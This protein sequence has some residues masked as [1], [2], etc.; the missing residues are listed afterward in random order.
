MVLVATALVSARAEIKTKTI[1]YMDGTT[2]LKGMMAWDG[3]QNG[4][5]PGILVIGEWWG[6]N[7]AN[8][9]RARRLA[10][11]GYVAFAPDMY[12]DGK[13]T[14]NPKQAGKWMRQITGNIDLW[15]RRARLGLDILKA[16]PNVASGKLAALGSSFGG[17]TA[18][19][20]AY[21][22]HDIKAAIS[23]ASSLPSAPKG[24]TSIK[25]RV[26]ALLGGNDTFVKAKS[27]TAFKAGLDRAKADWEMITYSGARHSFAT[28]GAEKHGMENL[29]YNKMADNR[30]WAAMMT[31]LDEVFK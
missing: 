11:A 24:I 5:R 12:G 22:G 3:G 25:P 1:I 29:V 6:L 26:L 14:N 2:A 16:D 13:I 20:M 17:A 23:I 21:A 10:A 7:E 9:N 31:L 4:K 18:I 27:I 19:Q 28:P 30:S 15:N 8:K